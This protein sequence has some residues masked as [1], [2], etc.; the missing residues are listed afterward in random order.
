MNPVRQAGPET[1]QEAIQR[2]IIPLVGLAVMNG[3][4]NLSPGQ[5]VEA[6]PEKFPQS[7]EEGAQ[8]VKFEPM[9]VEQA[10]FSPQ[11]TPDDPRVQ[12]GKTF[13]RY[14]GNAAFEKL[15]VKQI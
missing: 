14:A 9:V 4:D 2:R 7:I 8:V 12:E 13:Q 15:A 3:P 6:Q 5:P 10:L 11:A 1:A